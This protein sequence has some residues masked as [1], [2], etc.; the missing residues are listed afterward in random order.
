MPISTVAPCGLICDLCLGF[1]RTKNK[2]SGCTAEE[3]K[4]AFC[5]KCSIV[6]CPEKNGDSKKPCGDC[7]K[8]PCKRLKD[9]E[10]R[11][12]TNYGE[13][14]TDNFYQIKE[15]GLEQ[16]LLDF[17]KTWTCRECGE[18]LTVHRPQCLH[19]NAPNTYYK[20]KHK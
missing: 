6:N 9:L 15:K 7:S 10:K 3:N 12:F 19:C 11:Y 1:Q 5:V 4:S 13:S 14:L 17:E 20:R 16:F 2:C 8:F 18:L